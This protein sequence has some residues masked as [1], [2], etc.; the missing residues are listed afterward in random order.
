MWNNEKVT[1][2]YRKWFQEF[3]IA[4]LLI[5]KNKSLVFFIFEVVEKWCNL[6]RIAVCVWGR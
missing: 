5:E 1:I 6:F 4:L 2:V 3:D